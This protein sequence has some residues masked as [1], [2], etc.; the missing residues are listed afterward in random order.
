[1]AAGEVD[2]LWNQ[3]THLGDLNGGELV[4]ACEVGELW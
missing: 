4:A 3:I 2:E 1:M